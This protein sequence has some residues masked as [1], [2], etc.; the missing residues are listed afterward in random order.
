MSGRY[1][2]SEY[3]TAIISYVETSEEVVWYE[4]SSN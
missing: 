1:F 2:Y 4:D 3:I